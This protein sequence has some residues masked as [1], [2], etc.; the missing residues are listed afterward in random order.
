MVKKII[1]VTPKTDY[2]SDGKGIG[3][4]AVLNG[5]MFRSKDI[6]SVAVRNKKG[7]IAILRKRWSSISDRYSQKKTLQRLNLYNIPIIRGFLVFCISTIAG[8]KAMDYSA[9]MTGDRDFLKKDTII[10]KIVFYGVL[11]FLL[12]SIP[13]LIASFSGFPARTFIFCLIEGMIRISLVLLFFLS[14]GLMPDVRTIFEYHGAEHKVI[15]CYS[16]EKDVRKVSMDR[17]RRSSRFNIGC[18]SNQIMLELIL[19]IPLFL[20]FTSG[21][22]LYDMIFRL[23]LLPIII[24]I[25]VDFNY[26]LMRSRSKILQNIFL[27]PGMMF[28]RITVKEPD[29]KK[30]AVALSSLRQHFR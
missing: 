25:S 15:N 27:F 22:F 24:G 21:N 13:Y 8:L 18:S 7:K 23:M 28:Q 11:L 16:D 26:L 12:L 10:D 20:L 3:G 5:V 9:R 2:P 17:I 14:I 6:F 1:P 30:I 19:S 4:Q 29:D